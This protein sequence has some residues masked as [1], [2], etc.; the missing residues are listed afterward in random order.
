MSYLLRNVRTRP[1]YP[2]TFRVNKRVNFDPKPI[3]RDNKLFSNNI[4]QTYKCY[5]LLETSGQGLPIQPH[6]GL[7]KGGN[8]NPTPIDRVNKSISNNIRLTYKYY[9]LLETS[10]QGL[11]I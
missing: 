5:I 10:G 4:I 7:M 6:L 2:T 3:D 1:T 9:I 11:P 8:F